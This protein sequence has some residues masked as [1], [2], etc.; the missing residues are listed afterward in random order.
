VI[1]RISILLLIVAVTIT[2]QSQS[3]LKDL[4]ITEVCSKNET[5][6]ANSEG[7]YADW[8]EIYNAGSETVDLYGL[9]FSDNLLNLNKYTIAE[10]GLLIEPGA[11]LIIW[12]D[13]N[14]QLGTDHLDFKISE[15]ET[16]LISSEQDGIIDSLTIHRAEVDNSIGRVENSKTAEWAF[17]TVPT[18]GSENITQA[19]SDYALPVEFNYKSGYYPEAVNITLSSTDSSQVYYTLDN[20]SP[21]PDSISSKLYK[22]EAITITE[23]AVLRAQAYR[24]GYVPSEISSHLYIINQEYQLPVWSIITDSSN[25]YG[26]AGIYSNP[27]K[28]GFDWERY[29]QHCYFDAGGQKIYS[30]SGIRIQ[31]GNSVGMPKKSFRFHYRDIYGASRFKYPIFNHSDQ[32]TFRNIVF[33]S[34]YDDDLTSSGGTLLRDPLSTEFW[35]LTGNLASA[36]EWASL[37][38]NGNYWGIYNIRESV[39]EKF[40]EDHLGTGKFDLIRFQKTGPDLKHG[41][42]ADWDSLTSFI[43]SADFTSASAYNKACEQIDMNSLLNLLAFV[44]CSQYRSWTWGASVFKPSEPSGKWRFTIWDTDR[45]YLDLSWNGFTQYQFTA[46]EKWANFIPQKLLVNEQFK[47][48]LINRTADFLNEWFKTENSLST[49]DSIKS[50][51]EPAIESEKKRW[52]PTSNWEGATAGIASFLTNRPA[53]VR[54]QIKEYFAIENEYTLKL[55][56]VGKGTI[57]LNYLNLDSFPWEGV[58]FENIPVALTAIPAPGYKFTGWNIDESSN[59]I[60]SFSLTGDTELIAYFEKV[61]INEDILINEIMYHEF[62]SSPTGDWFELYNAGDDINIAGWWV[63]DG[64]VDSKF[65]ISENSYLKNGEYLV[66]AEDGKKY[67]SVIDCSSHKMNSSFGDGESGFSLSNSSECIY[68]FNADS[69]LIDSVC[70]D[71]GNSWPALAD[72]YGP[73]LQLSGTDLNNDLASSWTASQEVPFSPGRPN[74]SESLALNNYEDDDL[75]IYPNPAENVLNIE[76]GFASTIQIEIIDNFGMHLFRKTYNS[77][78]YNSPYKL[79]IS[80]LSSGMYIL[81]LTSEKEIRTLKFVVR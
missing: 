31:G 54:G 49:Y 32:S 8:L 48:D 7:K 6:L 34:G 25:L 33:R 30:N 9:N 51:I 43:Q 28:E 61:D 42:A 18:P 79:D 60:E 59:S 37:M 40:V 64:G 38:I 26:S 76:T 46:K 14:P 12:A 5:V 47:R 53:K 15:G 58:Y 73:S 70:Y 69:V 71:D 65:I 77:G 63:S 24:D 27:W 62:S 67:C 19:N 39:D 44:H 75:L 56:T 1:Q 29:A 22:G 20:S 45:A 10:N 55:N 17:F 57:I 80:N 11:Y 68:L 81:K 41:S 50:I 23:T 21:H 78:Q 13:G 4:L 52:K 16:V 74:F 35:R 66:L 3:V 72:G 36:S 2:V